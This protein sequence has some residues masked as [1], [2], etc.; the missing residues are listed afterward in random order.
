MLPRS[1]IIAYNTD[2][3]TIT[4]PRPEAMEDAREIAKNK[5]DVDNICKLKIETTIKVTGCLAVRLS[6]SIRVGPPLGP[7]RL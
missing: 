3:F 6:A 1:I 5:D 2:S 4:Y 7:S